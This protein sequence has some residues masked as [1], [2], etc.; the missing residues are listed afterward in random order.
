MATDPTKT[1]ADQVKRL[2]EALAQAGERFADLAIIIR[3]HGSYDNAGFM[4]AS[5]DRCQCV[6]DGGRFND[7]Y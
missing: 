5:A 7:P 1:T 6:L 3:K 4:Q 2:R